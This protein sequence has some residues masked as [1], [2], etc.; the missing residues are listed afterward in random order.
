[1]ILMADIRLN[2]RLSSEDHKALK[3]RADEERRTIA[4]VVRMAL[5]LKKPAK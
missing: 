2:I 3:A 4:E 1:M 5:G